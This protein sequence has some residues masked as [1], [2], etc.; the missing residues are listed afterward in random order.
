M[1]VIVE[2]VAGV[3]ALAGTSLGHSDWTVITQ[4]RVNAFADATGDRQWIHVDV[5]RA[6]RES[7]FGGPIAHGFLTL[8][9]I[10]R[11]LAE[12]IEIRGFSMGVN[13]GCNKVRFPAPAAIG[14]RVRAS[15]VVGELADVPGGV[16]LTII[17]TIA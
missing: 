2:G 1:T 4:E 15:A 9:L 5:G 10:P 16:Q 6:T 17:V 3:R 13:Y 14:R 12:I 11:L 7:S 8:A